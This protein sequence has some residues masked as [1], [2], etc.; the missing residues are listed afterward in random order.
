MV[1]SRTRQA[2]LLSAVVTCVVYLTYRAI[3]TFNLTTPYAIFAST[4]LFVAELYTGILSLL[5][6]LQVWRPSEPPQQPVLPDRTVDVFVPTYNEDVQILRTTLRA[7]VALDYPHRTYVLDDGRRPAVEA[8]AKELGVGYIKRD[9]NKHAKAGNMNNALKQTDGEFIV[10]L[11]ADH[12]PER[13]F[14]TRLLGYFA[15]EQLAY[16]QTPH[17]FYNFDSFQAR[18][19]ARKNYYWDEGQLFHEVIQP[20][21][22]R[23]LCSRNHH[24]GPA[25]RPAAARPRLEVPGHLR[26]TDR[27]SGGAGRDHVPHA[28]PSL[29][30]GQPEHLRL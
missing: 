28:A 4:A 17:A 19:S 12:V 23:R 13:N 9:D 20:G 22:N 2:L 15:D 14:I 1:V 10:I 16:V 11:D 27:R 21:R 8:L 26:A 29:G 7:C 25:H 24:G 6:L 30:R 5:Y 3:F 18:Y